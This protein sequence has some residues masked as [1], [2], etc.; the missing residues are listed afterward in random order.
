MRRL[1]QEFRNREG[2]LALVS[3]GP[4]SRGEVRSILPLWSFGWSLLLCP[5]NGP[6]SD[7]RPLTEAACQS[8]GEQLCTCHFQIGPTFVI[9]KTPWQHKSRTVLRNGALSVQIIFENISWLQTVLYSVG[10]HLPPP[11]HMRIDALERAVWI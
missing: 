9:C 11:P 1:E 3:E 4:R 7:H 2:A 6:G 8:S 10:W 5:E